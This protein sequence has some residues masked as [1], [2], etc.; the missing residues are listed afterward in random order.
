[1]DVETKTAIL[2]VTAAGAVTGKRMQADIEE[3]GHAFSSA[4]T[5]PLN[6]WQRMCEHHNVTHVVD[7]T[8]GSAA[9]AVA[10]SGAMQYEG[11]AANVEHQKWL[12]SILDRCI[13]YMVGKDGDMAAK[14]GAD[15]DF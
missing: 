8:P 12:D 9:L 10:A 13:M 6:L 15:A 3:K 1:M 7:F 5:K 14:L 2:G 4:E 11:I